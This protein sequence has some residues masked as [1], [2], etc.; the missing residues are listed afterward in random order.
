MTSNLPQH[1]PGHVSITISGAD[2]KTVLD[3][4]YALSPCHNISGPGSPWHVPGVPG[5]RVH[6]YGHTAPGDVSETCP[7]QPTEPAPA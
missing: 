1:E 3:M 4:A 7:C 2:E 6:V 5:V